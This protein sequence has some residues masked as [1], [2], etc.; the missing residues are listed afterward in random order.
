M[1]SGVSVSIGAKQVYDDVKKNKLHRY[2]VYCI[3]DE[4][5]I[6]VEIK[7]DR[8]ASYQDFLTQ[9]KE[10]KDQCRYCLF[11]FPAEAPQE[12]T[13]EPS[14]IALD[15]LVLMTWC[16]EGARVKQKMLYASSYDALK[17]SLVGVYKYVQACDFEELSQEAIEEALKKK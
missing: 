9:M 5:Q 14:K 8:N 17:K 4:K 16:P 6:E 15:R 3:K 10:L 1:A 2:V 11:D 12:G 7:G 13:N